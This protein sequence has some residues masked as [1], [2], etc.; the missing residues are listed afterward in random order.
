[1]PKRKKINSTIKNRPH[2]HQHGYVRGLGLPAYADPR[3]GAYEKGIQKDLKK[4][5]EKYDRIRSELKAEDEAT[6]KKLMAKDEAEEK[7][8]QKK[9]AEEAKKKKPA[10]KKKSA[11]KRRGISINRR[12]PRR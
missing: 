4:L 8:Y 12:K 9:L 6:I 10:P 7:A 11:P 1:M 2:L 5:R 3:P